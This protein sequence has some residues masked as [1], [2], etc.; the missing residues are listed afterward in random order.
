MRLLNHVGDIN[1]GIHDFTEFASVVSLQKL[2]D[3]V[4]YRLRRTYRTEIFTVGAVY[5]ETD[6]RRSLQRQID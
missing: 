4:V 1:L 6:D 5:R 2:K 3:V